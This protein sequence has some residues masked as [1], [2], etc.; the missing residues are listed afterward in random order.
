MPAD[1]YESTHF[2]LDSANRIVS[3]R[4]PHPQL[5]PLFSLVRGF[6]RVAWRVHISVPAPVAA[7]L[8]RSA[9]DERPSEDAR[10]V[11]VHA[12]RYLALPSEG[13]ADATSRT[14]GLAIHHGPAFEFP[15]SI[16]PPS[17]VVEIADERLLQ[18]NF[19]GWLS[20]EIAAGRGPAIAALANGVPVSV[21][22]CAR[23]SEIA[24]EAGVETAAPFRGRGLAARVVAAWALAVRASGLVP[25]YSTSWTN[26][27]S[28]AVARKLGLIAYAS[29][30]R[31]SAVSPAR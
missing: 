20:G 3:T 4:E 2:V 27:A 13:A 6:T 1:L 7:E 10:S 22:F 19:R 31:T 12:G 30:W 21:C 5:G 11:P 16:R 23:R 28:L 25:L 18:R 15:P 26:A 14:R 24:A 29:H 8:E 17:D 9:R